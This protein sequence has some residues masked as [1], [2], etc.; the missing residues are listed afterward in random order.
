VMEAMKGAERVP[1]V[2][3]D[4]IH[5]SEYKIEPCRACSSKTGQLICGK[6]KECACKDDMNKILYDKLLEADG[7][8][9]GSPVYFGT[10]SAQLKSFFDRTAWLKMGKFWALRDKVGGALSIGFGRH[11][12]QEI[13]LMAINAFFFIHGM[14]IVGDRCPVKRDWEE[15]GGV[16]SGVP[17][18]KASVVRGRAHF[19]AGWADSPY[20]LLGKDS[21]GIVNSQGLGEHVAEVSVWVKEHRPPLET[22]EYYATDESLK[23]E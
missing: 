21:Q 17:Y 8:V 23:Y 6:M 4:I 9:I 22:M 1:N 13:T 10:M 14:I 12:G 18:N 16:S 20:G 11:G 5:L 15:F 7:M 19:A 3:T 2:K